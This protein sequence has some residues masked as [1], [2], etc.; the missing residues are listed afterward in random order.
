MHIPTDAE[1]MDALKGMPIHQFSMNHFPNNVPVN[2]SLCRFQFD[3]ERRMYDQN[4]TMFAIG[5]HTGAIS[6]VGV[7]LF[8]KEGKLTK[9]MPFTCLVAF[10]YTHH[11]H[12]YNI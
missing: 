2:M 5:E 7:D 4:H 9:Q 10:R 11:H 1:S 6:L 8:K 3:E 12:R